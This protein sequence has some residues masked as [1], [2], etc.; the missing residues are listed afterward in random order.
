MPKWAERKAKKRGGVK[1]Y[2]MVRRGGHLMRCMIT[3]KAGPRGGHTVCYRVR[4]KHK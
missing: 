2:R 4:K 3:K 1:R